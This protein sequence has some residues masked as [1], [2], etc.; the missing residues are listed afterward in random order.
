M[1]SVLYAAQWFLTVFSCPF[2]PSFACRVIDIMLVERGDGI[3]QRTAMAVMAEC[4]SDLMELDDFEDI[5][6]LLKV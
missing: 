5:I 1:V 2:P 3:L 4:A 6:T